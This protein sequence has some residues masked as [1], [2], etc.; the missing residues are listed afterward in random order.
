[1]QHMS[2]NNSCTPGQFTAS[3][4]AASVGCLGMSAAGSAADPHEAAVNKGKGKGKGKGKNK[5]KGTD[6]NAEPAWHF[7][8]R[9]KKA[10]LS[11]IGLLCTSLGLPA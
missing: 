4:A 2:A 8:K 11:C 9:T 7:P 3:S 5:G 6:E 10:N 1:M